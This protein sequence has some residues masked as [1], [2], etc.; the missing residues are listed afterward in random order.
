MTCPKV[1]VFNLLLSCPPKEILGYPT[2]TTATS[3]VGLN[4]MG[5]VRLTNVILSNYFVSLTKRTYVLESYSVLFKISYMLGLINSIYMSMGGYILD[6]SEKS[7]SDSVS[8]LSTRVSGIWHNSLF[9]FV[10][11]FKGTLQE[12]IIYDFVTTSYLIG[13]GNSI[14]SSIYAVFYNVQKLLN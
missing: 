6:D 3:N 2:A 9:L 5:I 14:Y 4:V 7:F 11:A 10:W 13:F 1:D 12:N 8:D